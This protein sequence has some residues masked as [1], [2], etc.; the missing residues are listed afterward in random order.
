MP[1]CLSPYLMWRMLVRVSCSILFI[2]L[3]LTR[4]I[5]E[6]TLSPS[7]LLK[8]IAS[9]D[10]AI[11]V[12]TTVFIIQYFHPKF[13]CLTVLPVCPRVECNCLILGFK[14]GKISRE[15]LQHWN[16]SE[17]WLGLR[18][19]DSWTM[20]IV[21]SATYMKLNWNWI[22]EAVDLSIFTYSFRRRERV[23]G[24]YKLHSWLSD[25]IWVRRQW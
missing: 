24:I 19:N 1:S 5:C 14:T 22:D 8:G 25:I 2:S 21:K 13:L 12:S 16:R 10:R 4:F 23:V 17:L 15:E 11:K 6:K 20:Y 3:D 7:A 9:Y 18:Q